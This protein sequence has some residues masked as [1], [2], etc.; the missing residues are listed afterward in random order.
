MTMGQSGR[1]SEAH[2]KLFVTL[3]IRSESVFEHFRSTL[4]VDHFE[5]E[6]F[7]L[8]WYVVS[9]HYLE[10][11]S[12]PS[13][14]AIHANLESELQQN[15]ISVATESIAELEDFLVYAFDEELFS[16]V[17]LD[18]PSFDRFAYRAGKK[19]V[20]EQTKSEM[21]QLLSTQTS[22]EQLPLLAQAINAKF[23]L[24]EMSGS[25]NEPRWS[26][27]V[28][29]EYNISREART[30]GLS[31]F[32]KYLGG[33][34]A[35]K[36]CY[37][38]LAPFGTCKTTLAIMLNVEAAKQEFAESNAEDTDGRVGISF[39]ISYETPKPELQQRSLVYAARLS[40]GSVN[41][42][43]KDGFEALGNDADNPLEYEQKRFE[44][45]IAVG[46][47]KPERVRVQE[48]L[49]WLNKHVCFLDFS[50][51]GSSEQPAGTRGVPEIAMEIKK[52]LKLRGKANHYVKN[53]VIDY[54]GAMIDRDETKKAGKDRPEDHKYISQTVREIGAKIARHF[55]CHVWIL[56]QLKG[57]AN[58][59]KGIPKAL[60]HTDAAGSKSF[61]E[62]LDFCFTISTLNSDQCG[63][64][65][66][67]KQRA[68][69]PM[70]PS[71]VKV[72]GNF[73]E[74]TVPANL[75]IDS[76]GH[77]V[78]KQT[79]QMS[80]DT[81]SQFDLESNTTSSSASSVSTIT[82]E[83]ADFGLDGEEDNDSS[84][85]DYYT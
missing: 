44:S 85:E 60:H 41:N 29:F 72:L 58:A 56:H 83:D 45:L 61:A 75:V 25:S 33:G 12:L 71:V 16:D 31:F 22:L 47:F 37:G 59:P 26:F 76:Q 81:F 63:I 78:D 23:E 32:D 14:A 74:V 35:K 52:E 42:M 3:L 38:L 36:E 43:G 48:A 64:L 49:P 28:G 50:G 80:G 7:K 18:D 77:I 34:A 24:I 6:H 66:C 70:L 20:A 21:Q 69:F 73:N 19:L 13:Y 62:A 79:N 10:Y 4:T 54:L 1:L 2:L 57:E 11:N 27:P 53:V 8:L 5:A 9:E 46:V 39:F 15:E 51:A 30:T 55:D 17:P 65:N 68:S 82:G 40:R 67:S 84:P